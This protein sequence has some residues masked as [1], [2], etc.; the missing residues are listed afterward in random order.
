[1]ESFLVFFFNKDTS[2][3]FHQYWFAYWLL[4][5]KIIQT[6]YIYIYIDSLFINKLKLI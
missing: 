3:I 4:G 2:V 6:Q 5:N 1:M